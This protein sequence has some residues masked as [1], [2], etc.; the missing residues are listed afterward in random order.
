MNKEKDINRLWASAGYDQINALLLN[1]IHYLKD[2]VCVSSLIC[3]S[4]ITLL[5]LSFLS[6]GGFPKDIFRQITKEISGNDNLHIRILSDELNCDR[7]KEYIFKN[8][9]WNF[10][11]HNIDLTK[12][13]PQNTL[14]R[15]RD[16]KYA[17]TTGAFLQRIS[18][19]NAGGKRVFGWIVTGFEEDTY[20]DGSYLEVEA[21]ADT[22]Q[23]LTPDYELSVPDEDTLNNTEKNTLPAK[24]RIIKML[25]DYGAGHLNFD[26]HFV[27]SGGYIISAGTEGFDYSHGEVGYYEN[28]EDDTL[29]EF[30]CA[31][32][33]QIEANLK[34][35][36]KS[37]G[38]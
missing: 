37:Q 17:F 21:Y 15:Y 29:E 4:N 22:L 5:E 32:E 14:T 1:I 7:N 38:V 34:I 28:L 10:D 2:K 27:T 18:Y 9:R 12:K 6:S 36:K 11:K 8:G 26:Q 35:F 23:G 30:A 20:K 16:D 31:V 24:T 13:A 19:I 33:M 3:D 25:I